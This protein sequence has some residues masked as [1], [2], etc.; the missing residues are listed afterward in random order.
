M[1]SVVGL[2]GP[3]TDALF[4]PA[5]PACRSDTAQARTLCP[6]CW[7]ETAFLTGRG[8]RACGRKVPGLGIRDTSFLCDTCQKYP[9]AWGRGVAVFA[10]QGAGRRL[11]LGLKHGDR[12]DTVPM[13]AG[14][15]LRAGRVLVDETELILPVPM[16]W[17]RR[18]GRRFNQSAELARALAGA[19][20]APTHFAANLLRRVRRT[21]SQDGRDRAARAENIAGAFALPRGSAGRLAGKRVLLVDDVLTTGATLNACA[22]LCRRAEAKAVDILVL[23]LVS[24]DEAPYLRDP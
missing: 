3:L 6:D 7:A 22:R 11:I 13:L 17:T 15:M 19:A 2:A 8:C 4:P 24:F 1:D 9:P 21:G 10:Y 16:H 14:W 23:A 5:C 20:G 12:L 18:L